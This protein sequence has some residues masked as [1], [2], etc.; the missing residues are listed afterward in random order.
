MG[1]FDFLKG[2]AGE[3]AR[4]SMRTADHVERK[5]GDRM[6]KEQR[7]RFD[8]ARGGLDAIDEWSRRKDADDR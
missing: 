1:F 4:D 2:L 5:Y 7:E 6:S 3:M 8:R